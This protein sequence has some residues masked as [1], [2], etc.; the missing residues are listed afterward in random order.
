MIPG[1]VWTPPPPASSPSG[2]EGG[3]GC[4]VLRVGLVNLFGSSLPSCALA[5]P[6]SP[7]MTW[8]KLATSVSLASWEVK[9]GCCC[10]GD[11]AVR[12]VPQY[13]GRPVYCSEK[14]SD[15]KA[16]FLKTSARLTFLSFQAD[17]SPVT[18]F[19]LPPNGHQQH[20]TN[21]I[22]LFLFRAIFLL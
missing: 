12:K 14:S 21:V 3:R 10:G 15:I 2:G 13:P 7:R 16:P 11:G 9:K 6:Q 19:L 22:D 4:G 17:I 1:P 5:G 18:V 8:T 20:Y